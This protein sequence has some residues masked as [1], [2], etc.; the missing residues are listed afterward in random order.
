[1]RIFSSVSAIIGADPATI[2]VARAVTR[3]T[4]LVQPA[5]QPAQSGSAAKPA[6]TLTSSPSPSSGA[7]IEAGVAIL[8]R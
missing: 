3:A 5:A 4:T 7:A 8:G 2:A 1:M 6:V